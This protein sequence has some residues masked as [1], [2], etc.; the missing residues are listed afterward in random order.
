VKRK[1]V[2]GGEVKGHP[3]FPNR[4]P[5]LV[6][7]III[8]KKTSMQQRRGGTTFRPSG[9]QHVKLQACVLTTNRTAA[10]IY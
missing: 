1:R 4:S 10:V 8:C 2:Q 6:T 5:P 7:A 3:I 9:N